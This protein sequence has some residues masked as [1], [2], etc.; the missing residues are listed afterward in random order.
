VNLDD[1]RAKRSAERA[2]VT[3][4]ERHLRRVP[5][6]YVDHY[7]TPRPHRSLAQSGA[8]DAERI[9]PMLEKYANAISS[10]LADRA[11]KATI[12]RAIYGRT[13]FG[14]GDKAGRL[15]HA[16]LGVSIAQSDRGEPGE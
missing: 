10:A 7:N 15:H 16:L 11:D 4:G 3:V 8:A 14:D 13:A 12:H 5:A 1:Y 9:E 6:E 2:L